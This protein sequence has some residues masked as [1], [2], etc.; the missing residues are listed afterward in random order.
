[1]KRI[2]VPA[3]LLALLL[4]AACGGQES[5][6]QPVPTLDP[7]AAQGKKVFSKECALCHALKPDAVLRGPSL[8]G[9]ATNAATRI[10]GNDARDYI[11]NSILSPG[12]YVVDGFDNIMIDNFGEKLTAEEVDAVAAYLLTLQE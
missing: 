1:M 12:D 4:L 8:H 2:I 10:P 5:N 7:I 3:M 11:Y 9:I 6:S